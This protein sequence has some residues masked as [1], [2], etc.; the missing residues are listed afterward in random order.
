MTIDCKLRYRPLV[1]FKHCFLI[2][3][4]EIICHRVR[5]FEGR[6]AILDN[7][8]SLLHELDLDPSQVRRKLHLLHLLFCLHIELDRQLCRL[9]MICPAI[10]VLGR[11]E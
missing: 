11:K 1:V 2:A 3:V 10:V 5:P 6:T 7:V 8:D 4:L 9:L